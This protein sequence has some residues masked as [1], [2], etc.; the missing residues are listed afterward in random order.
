MVLCEIGT[1]AGTVAGAVPGAACASVT[2]GVVVV[3]TLG[4]WALSNKSAEI[5]SA[6]ARVQVDLAHYSD[7]LQGLGPKIDTYNTYAAMFGLPP[8]SWSGPNPPAD[9]N[10]PH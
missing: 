6:D 10:L 2:I 3:I 8:F 5:S 7:A 9:P 4:Q 1:I